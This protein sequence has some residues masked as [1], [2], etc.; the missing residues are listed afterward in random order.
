MCVLVNLHLAIEHLTVFTEF[1]YLIGTEVR[2]ESLYIL[3]TAAQL[4]DLNLNW[5]AS[6]F[7]TFAS[8]CV[9]QPVNYL[10]IC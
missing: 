4:H 2:I 3:S 10:S 7:V 8:K 1:I 5:L 9:S 6:T